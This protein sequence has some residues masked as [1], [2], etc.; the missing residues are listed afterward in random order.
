ME[1]VVKKPKPI[2]N[3][4]LG[5]W[6]GLASFGMLFATLFLSYGLMR[7]RAPV[8]PPIGV[9][10][11]PKFLPTIATLI[12]LGSSYLIE[13]AL[14]A[15]QLGLRKVFVQYWNLTMAAGAA[16]LIT[17]A[18][19]WREV[20]QWGT[21]FNSNL[22]GSVFYTMTGLHALHILGGIISLLVVFFKSKRKGFFTLQL[23][24]PSSE[25]PRLTAMYWHFMD[26]I[27]V[28]MYLLLVWF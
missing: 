1:G 26:A 15:Y 24:R 16:F 10:P 12:L 7:V 27:W 8:W 25:A 22:F 28:V 13:N 9:D 23:S 3:A 17:Q 4:E 2:S 19:V 11:L 21:Q 20:S 5:M 14:R 6:I 18:L